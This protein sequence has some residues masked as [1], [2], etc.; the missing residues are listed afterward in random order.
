[1]TSFCHF[2]FNIAPLIL[3]ILVGF[4][5][6][7]T[8]SFMLITRKPTVFARVEPSKSNCTVQKST[9]LIYFSRTDPGMSNIRHGARV[10]T[11]CTLSVEKLPEPRTFRASF[12][13]FVAVVKS[14]AM[15]TRAG[16]RILTAWKLSTEELSE[17][18]TF[19]AF[20]AIFVAVVKH[21]AMCKTPIINR[22]GSRFNTVCTL[23]N[24]KEELPGLERS[25]HFSSY[26]LLLCS[27][28]CA[29]RYQY[30][31]KEPTHSSPP[32]EF[33]N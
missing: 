6:G 4:L 20:L 9:H 31:H 23:S 10:R 12:D 30:S 2:Q 11:V 28:R 13:I 3:G 16:A 8:L 33:R 27:L 18:R 24:C 14:Y 29:F 22:H 25:V 21:Y 7:M 5:L 26:S 15:C 1:M 32:F 17:P 19:R